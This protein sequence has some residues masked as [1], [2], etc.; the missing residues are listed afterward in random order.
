MHAALIRF[1]SIPP[2]LLMKYAKNN[3][4]GRFYIF[5]ILKAEFFRKGGFSQSL[6]FPVCGKSPQARSFVCAEQK[7]RRTMCAYGKKDSL[8]FPS[9]GAVAALRFSPD[10]QIK[11]TGVP[12]G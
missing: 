11:E 8:P 7:K 10:K 3:I 4:R 9:F 6:V 12:R 1:M 5:I 2:V